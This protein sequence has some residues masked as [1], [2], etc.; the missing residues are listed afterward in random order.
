MSER[1]FSH[2]HGF[3]VRIF[4]LAIAGH[5]TVDSIRQVHRLCFHPNRR[6]QWI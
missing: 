2:V 5:W 1:L 4:S 3:T 6:S